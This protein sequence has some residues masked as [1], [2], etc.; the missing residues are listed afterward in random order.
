MYLISG[1]GL[2][3]LGE[4]AS[5][6]K[7]GGTVPRIDSRRQTVESTFMNLE[8]GATSVISKINSGLKSFEFTVVEDEILGNNMAKVTASRVPPSVV[9]SQSINPSS[10]V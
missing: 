1:N 2:I 4:F 9:H 3:H 8:L 7:H 6:E 5:V 10:D